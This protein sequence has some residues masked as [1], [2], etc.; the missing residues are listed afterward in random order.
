MAPPRAPCSASGSMSRTKLRCS[1][2]VCQVRRSAGPRYPQTVMIALV[3]DELLRKVLNF[4]TAK[5]AQRSLGE[6][7]LDPFAGTVIP[8]LIFTGI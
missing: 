8:A 5:A 7:L 2:I 4:G 6:Q 1:S 3:D